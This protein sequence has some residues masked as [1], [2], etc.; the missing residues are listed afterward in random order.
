MQLAYGWLHHLFGAGLDG[1][2]KRPPRTAIARK[3]K[4]NGTPGSYFF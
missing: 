2:T 4:E 3:I 1:Q